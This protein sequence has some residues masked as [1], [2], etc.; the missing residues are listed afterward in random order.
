MTHERRSC[1]WLRHLAA[2]AILLMTSSACAAKHEES[3][4]RC[5]VTPELFCGPYQSFWQK[6]P[7]EERQGIRASSSFGTVPHR[8][9]IEL[10]IRNAYGLWSD[11]PLTRFFRSHGI[12]H[13]DIMSD[14]FL[15]GFIEY[16]HGKAV[17][18]GHVTDVVHKSL[19]PPPP[20]P[21]PSG[22]NKKHG[23][24]D[25]AQRNPGQGD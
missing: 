11:T 1:I 21:P 16:L 24:P 12:E 10:Q 14:I 6:L 9:G 25:A 18:M 23:G 20:P 8:R 2:I 13:P 4:P 15:Q 5:S 22:W 3:A 7:T 17:D 19:T